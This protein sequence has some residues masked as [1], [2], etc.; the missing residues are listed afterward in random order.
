MLTLECKRD[1]CDEDYPEEFIHMINEALSNGQLVVYPT[2]TLYGLGAD[3]ER[4]DLIK[5]VIEVKDAPADK[6]ISTAYNSLE[7]A[8][9]YFDIPEQAKKIRD[10]FLPGP[11]TLVIETEEGTEG[12]RV[13]D[14]P[15]PKKI[16]S[17]FGPITATSA[18]LHGMADPV[19]IKDVEMQ[20]GDRVKIY[21]DCGPCRYGKGTTVLKIG[22][23]GDLEI[24]REGVIS[25]ETIGDKFEF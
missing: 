24:V 12:I 22:K 8:E 11:L 1:D 7:Q 6:N 5:K 3:A 4:D 14:H 23:S 19:E 17:E 20:L 10:E 13:P 25:K 18:N 2:E 16:T 9:E 15:V 21:I